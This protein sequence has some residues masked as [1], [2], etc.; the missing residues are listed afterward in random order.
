MQ[1]KQ[2]APLRRILREAEVREV[3]GLSRSARWRLTREG[4]F[5]AP[6]KLTDYATGWD[7][8]EIQSW[9]LERRRERDAEAKLSAS[10][11]SIGGDPKAA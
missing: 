2:T 7:S 4:R 10:Q 5:P 3:T 1:I 6:I 9:I 11:S 8:E